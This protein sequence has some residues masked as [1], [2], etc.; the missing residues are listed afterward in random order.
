MHDSTVR[1][2]RLRAKRR[3]LGWE[4]FEL[5]LPP[6]NATLLT[7]LKLPGEALHDTVGRALRALATLQA[8]DAQGP[9]P[10]PQERPTR[11][12]AH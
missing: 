10:E 3:Q 8:Q 9:V 11:G 1:K 6:D 12:R 4:Q 7:E 5:W 2:R